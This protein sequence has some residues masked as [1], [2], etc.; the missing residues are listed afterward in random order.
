[1]AKY[2]QKGATIQNFIPWAQVQL[3]KSARK[4]YGRIIKGERLVAS[5]WWTS[6]VHKGS[7]LTHLRDSIL[8][9]HYYWQ[10]EL[11]LTKNQPFTKGI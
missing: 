5:V 9:R 3:T 7:P 4:N 6:E 10:S 8:G 2:T 11:R 1:M